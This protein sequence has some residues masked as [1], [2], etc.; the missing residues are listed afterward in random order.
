[1]ILLEHL[2]TIYVSM[3]CGDNFGVSCIGDMSILKAVAYV[4]FP[5]NQD[6][7]PKLI[8]QK[9]KRKCQTHI[10]MLDICPYNVCDVL[11]CQ[12]NMALGHA[13]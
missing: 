9:Y 3:G 11:P 8:R 4:T 2:V 6:V 7:L 12:L 1:L 10:Y 13:C 5:Y